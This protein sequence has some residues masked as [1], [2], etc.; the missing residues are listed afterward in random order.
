[1]TMFAGLSGLALA[2][3]SVFAFPPEPAG[4]ATRP[5]PPPLVISSMTGAD[6]FRFYCGPCHGADGRGHGPVA[7]SLRTAPSDLTALSR[8]H[9]GSFP[10]RD[11]ER[12]LAGEE[13][14]PIAAHGSKDMPV[15]GPIFRALDPDARTRTVRVANIVAHIEA[16]QAK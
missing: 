11:V 7:S 6:L 9:D 4:Q 15:W 13:S 8:R 3:L 10:R 2:A 16:M 5:S 14:G 12:Y 1:M